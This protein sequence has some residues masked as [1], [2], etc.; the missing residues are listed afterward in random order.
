MRRCYLCGRIVWPWQR[1]IATAAY[2]LDPATH[3]VR[4]KLERWHA[5]CARLSR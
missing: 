2:R 5:S 1:S 4:A 3:T